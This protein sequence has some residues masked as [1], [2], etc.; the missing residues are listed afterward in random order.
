[1]PGYDISSFGATEQEALANL[2]EAIELYL[3]DIPSTEVSPNITD[4]TVGDLAIA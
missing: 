1:M 2:K 3:E 4:V